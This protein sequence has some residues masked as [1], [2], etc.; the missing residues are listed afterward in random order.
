MKDFNEDRPEILPT[1]LGETTARIIITTKRFTLAHCFQRMTEVA[2][3]LQ[4]VNIIG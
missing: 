2:Y 4:R 1:G 3:S